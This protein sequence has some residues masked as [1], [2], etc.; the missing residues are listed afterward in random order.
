MNLVDL[1]AILP[2]YIELAFGDAAGGLAIL[3]VLRMARILRMV[4]LGSFEMYLGLVGEIP[5]ILY[6][7]ESAMANAPAL[8]PEPSAPL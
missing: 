6:R 1:F 8:V 2:G 4:K 5:W 7:Y 3:R